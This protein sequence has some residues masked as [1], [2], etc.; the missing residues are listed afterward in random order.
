MIL[1]I[2]EIGTKIEYVTFNFEPIWFEKN[3]SI[4]NHD[5]SIQSTQFSFG[6]DTFNVLNRNTVK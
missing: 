2:F 3:I 4:V 1:Q 6:F 5:D